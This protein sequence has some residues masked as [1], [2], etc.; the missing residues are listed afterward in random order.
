MDI[1]ER[2]DRAGRDYPNRIAH[3]G[4]SRTLTY[5]ELA[6]KSDAIARH[7][8]ERFAGD[9]SPV[10]VLGHKEPEMLIGFVGAVKSGRP[11]IPVDVSIPA[12]RAA[13]IAHN[14]GSV[15]VLTAAQIATLA[16]ERSAAKARRVDLDDPFYI[17]F[18]YGSTGEPKGVVITLRCLT[19]FL[20]WML[21]E[22]KFARAGETFLSVTESVAHTTDIAPGLPRRQLSCFF[23]KRKAASQMVPGTA[24]QHYAGVCRL[25]TAFS[26]S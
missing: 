13:R 23:P 4:N 10:V 18:T 21:E 20:D 3:V 9:Y 19:T 12:E 26:W 11:Y 1:I 15:A 8:T 2:I 25:Q 14:S 24:R 7:F 17:I 16:N 5:G 22:Q 6:G